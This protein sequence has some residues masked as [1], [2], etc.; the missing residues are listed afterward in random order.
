VSRPRRS[1]YD[2]V[3]VAQILLVV[4]ISAAIPTVANASSTDPSLGRPS[5]AH[6]T[7]LHAAW[8]P[9][10]PEPLSCVAPVAL[11]ATEQVIDL[12]W[13]G[14]GRKIAATR[15]VRSESRRTVTGYEEDP[16]IQIVGV[17]ARTLDDVGPGM[18]P[19]WSGSGTF[20]S[21]WRAGRLHVTRGAAPVTVI[22]SSNPDTRWVGDEL[23]YFLHDEI[24]GWSASGDRLISRLDPFHTPRFPR[25]D[26]YFSAD[27]ARFIVT[28][29][30]MDGTA[31]RYTG[32][33]ATGSVALLDTPGTTYTE[34]APVGQT[35]LVRTEDWI[36]LRDAA[37]PRASAPIADLPGA[38]HG[39]TADGRL[40]MG[41][42]SPTLPLG[43]RPDRF[44]VWED[45]RLTATATLPNLV[46]ARAFSP[47]GRYFAGIA[48]TGLLAT[49]LEVYR[50]GTRL[51][52]EASRADPVAR[53]RQAEIDGAGRRFVRPVAGYIS[54]FLQGLHTG[55]DVAAPFGGTITTVEDGTVTFVGWVPVGGRAVCVLH[56]E[57]VESCYYHTSV[58]YVRVGQWVARGEF[59]AAVGMSGL[60]TGPHVHWE[61]K[62]HG[63]IVDPL[64]R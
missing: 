45:G 2:D 4:A 29:Y 25:D 12:A 60:T 3:R 43:T 62:Q 56:Y 49:G 24:R 5:S 36:E 30:S 13:S 16:F 46:G 44:M 14:D 1:D 23:R 11:P 64:A 38:V 27:G 40:L 10:P 9:T 53:A 61:V 47:D 58:S 52:A 35:L 31:Y 22:D 33:V 55:I 32:D 48:R 17:D 18:R 59:L 7:A 63:R 39:W 57:G 34:W 28:R 51:R 26:A 50:C 20:L 21:F 42:V 41:K 37:G 19:R 15:I 6:P 8:D 54:Q